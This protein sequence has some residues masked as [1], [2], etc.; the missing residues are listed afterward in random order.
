VIFLGPAAGISREGALDSGETLLV[1]AQKPIGEGGLLDE[2]GGDGV[3]RAIGF[4]PIP[5]GGVEFGGVFF[6]EENLLGAA[7]VGEAIQTGVGLAVRRAWACCPAVTRSVGRDRGVGAVEFGRIEVHALL[8][9][10]LREGSARGGAVLGEVVDGR[11]DAKFSG[12]VTEDGEN[13]EEADYQ[14]NSGAWTRY[15]F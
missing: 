8:L 3:L 2:I 6:G 7:A 9:V 15:G 14:T 5:D 4:E 1:A 13:A 10:S 12:I 11:G